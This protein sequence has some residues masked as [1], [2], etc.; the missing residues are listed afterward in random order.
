MAR[1]GLTSPARAVAQSVAGVFALALV[2]GYNDSSASLVAGP[3]AMIAAGGWLA[4]T[5]GSL[6]SGAC[7]SWPA[8]DGP[9]RR[10]GLGPGPR[11]H[12]RWTRPDPLGRSRDR[13]GMTAG[14]QRGSHGQ[15][16]PVW[17]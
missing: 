13:S 6:C 2:R 15:G 3:A 9:S 4:T 5:S 7:P 14:V 11:P 16:M 10:G 1:A 8:E 17:S 12:G